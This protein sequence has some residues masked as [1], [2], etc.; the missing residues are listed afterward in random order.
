MTCFFWTGT[1]N[2]LVTNSPLL[3]NK[4]QVNT[5]FQN[6]KATVFHHSL[7]S[8]LQAQRQ[9]LASRWP[10]P[11]AAAAA[12]SLKATLR[13]CRVGDVSVLHGSQLVLLVGFLLF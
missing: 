6:N 8:P 7:T 9:S 13:A 12:G 4:K 1:K 3:Q 5:R 2:D 10:H 11:K